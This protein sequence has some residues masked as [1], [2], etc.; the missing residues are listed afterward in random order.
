MTTKYLK[1]Q[2]WVGSRA[3]TLP[4]GIQSLRQFARHCATLRP[5]TDDAANKTQPFLRHAAAHQWMDKK[6][7]RA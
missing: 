6:G 1:S 3:S 2:F 7:M 5:T 4:E